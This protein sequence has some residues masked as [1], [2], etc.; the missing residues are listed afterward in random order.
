MGKKRRKT[1]RIYVKAKR[2][3]RKAKIPLLPIVGLVGT[4]AVQ[5]SIESAMGGQWTAIPKHLSALAGLDW[6]GKFSFE[7]AKD[8]WFPILAGV[9][10]H[11]LASALGINRLFARAPSPL[12]K[13][14]L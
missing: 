10:G 7:V 6:N 1:R 11:K 4:P 8:N 2:R 9:I 5:H 12:N 14:Q 13:F 3:V